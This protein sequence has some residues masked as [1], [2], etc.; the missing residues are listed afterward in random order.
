MGYCEYFKCYIDD[1]EELEKKQE[2]FGEYCTFCDCPDCE[3]YER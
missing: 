1:Y 3:W 2:E